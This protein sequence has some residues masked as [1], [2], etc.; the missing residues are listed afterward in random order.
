MAQQAAQG[1]N[2]RRL[3]VE[4]VEGSYRLLA[5]MKSDKDPK[6]IGKHRGGIRTW[7]QLDSVVRY[8]E[9]KFPQVVAVELFLQPSSRVELE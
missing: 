2:V 5:F 9:D 3:V 4:R 7:S 8:V 1:A 6:T